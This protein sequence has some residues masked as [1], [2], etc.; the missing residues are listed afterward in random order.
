MPSRDNV[1]SSDAIK[2]AQ[3]TQGKRR[4]EYSWD[5]EVGHRGSDIPMRFEE[6]SCGPFFDEMFDAGGQPREGC[7]LLVRALATIPDEEVLHRQRAAETSLLHM[8]TT[9]HV[10]GSERGVE[11]S[12]HLT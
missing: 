11:K 5:E 1:S 4:S 12:S 10:Y 3:E 6:Y 2:S 7:A 8:G 9:F